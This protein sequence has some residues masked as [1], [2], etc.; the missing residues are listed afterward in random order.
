MSRF[1]ISS[2]RAGSIRAGP[3]LI[4]FIFHFIFV[5]SGGACFFVR[6][7]AY[8]TGGCIKDTGQIQSNGSWGTLY[9]MGISLDD[10]SCLHPAAQFRFLDNGAML[11]LER[12][13]CLAAFNRNGS[14]YNLDMFY[15]Y[16][17]SEAACAQKPSEGIYRAIK[18]TAEEGL[19]VY[20]RQNKTKPFEIWCAMNSLIAITE[21]LPKNWTI[22]NIIELR[23]PSDCMKN[24]NRFKRRFIFGRLLL[25]VLKHSNYNNSGSKN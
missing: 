21:I 15:I 5:F 8:Y 23:P 14:G 24:N 3:S 20:Y 22:A 17:G 4:T 12:Q 11:S 7:L 9:F 13:G 25:K 6:S 18:Q 16:V 1:Y 10:G 19:S 2:T